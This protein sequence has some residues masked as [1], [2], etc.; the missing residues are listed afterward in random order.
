MTP[1]VE[2]LSGFGEKA[3][4]AILVEWRGRRLLLDAGGPLHPDEPCRWAEGLDVDAVL[5]SHDHVDHI[6]GVPRLPA[7]LPLYCTPEVARALPPGREW[8]PLA[9]R[10]RQS[11][12]GVPVTTGQAGHSLGGVWL[13][14]GI[15]DGLFYS[16]D[17]C[18]ESRLFPFD[19]PPA[20]AV[21]LLDA[22]YGRYD[23]PQARCRGA[24]ERCLT[25]PLVLPAPVSGRALEMALWL[26]ERAAR[27]GVDW[28]LDETCRE[29]LERLLRLPRSLRRDG[30]DAALHRLLA[31]PRAASPGLW[32]AADRDDDPGDW[33]Q[34]R[35]LHTGYLTPRRRRQRAAGEIDWL[36]WNVHLRA[37]HLRAL[38]RHLR[39]RRVLP[40]FTSEAAEVGDWLATPMVPAPRE[41][42]RDAAGSPLRLH[43][44]R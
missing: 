7:D 38:A 24:L 12:A 3:A 26:E 6:G 14:L 31:A 37:S 44:T 33:P 36:R 25:R 13:H 34:H 28:N 10:G 29:A 41:E 39:A 9:P 2:V 32:L 15:G 4:A 21:A 19:R 18:L 40:L 5:I 22:S 30:H 17:A 1:R 42:E 20:A 23:V 8:R 16:G 43:A 27:L 35:L 11:V